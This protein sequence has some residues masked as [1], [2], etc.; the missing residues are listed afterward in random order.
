LVASAVGLALALSGATGVAEASS[1]YSST[2]LGDS[3]AAYWRLGES[4]GT[5]CHDEVASSDGTYDPGTGLGGTG[6]IANDANTAI[7]GNCT[8]PWNSGIEFEGGQALTIEAWAVD[9]GNPVVG[10]PLGG[11]SLSL[12]YQ[13][14]FDS[15]GGISMDFGG[16]CSASSDPDVISDSDYH[17]IVGTFDGGDVALYVD[18]E[19]VGGGSDCHLWPA[20]PYD[21]SIG[22]GTAIDEV[23]LYPYAL[24]DTQVADHYSAGISTP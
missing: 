20:W 10:T 2:I 11:S 1:T 23:A 8:V 7:G 16:H 3:P 9:N 6:A 18:G 17:Y 4:S 15:F 14:S 5:T 22:G 12:S 13:L 21:L 19:Y 24:T